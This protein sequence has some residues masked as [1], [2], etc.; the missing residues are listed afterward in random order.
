MKED[1][2]GIGILILWI[3]SFYEFLKS[4]YYIFSS[5]GIIILTVLGLF[6]VFIKGI[7]IGEKYAYKKINNTIIG[8]FKISDNKN[9]EKIFNCGA[10]LKIDYDKKGKPIKI[11]A[12]EIE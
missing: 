4:E 8:F 12:V 10:L 9:Q 6:L 11:S 3:C 1:L 2:I 7:E 5:V